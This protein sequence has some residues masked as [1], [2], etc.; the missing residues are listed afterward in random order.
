MDVNSVVVDPRFQRLQEYLAN[1][2]DIDPPIFVRPVWHTLHK[3]QDAYHFI[4]RRANA[5][6]LLVVP[7]AP[8]VDLFVAERH[9]PL[10]HL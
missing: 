2:W 5:L 8:D 10:N 3:S 7:R 6:H 1:G 9:L 4:L